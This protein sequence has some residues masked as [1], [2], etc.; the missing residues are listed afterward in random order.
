MQSSLLFSY[1]I[2]L[3]TAVSPRDIRSPC[4]CYRAQRYDFL[5]RWPNITTLDNIYHLFININQDS[6]SCRKMLSTFPKT[7]STFQKTLST[8]PKM[9]STFPKTLSTF[10]REG[11]CPRAHARA[12]AYR[13]RRNQK[14]TFTFTRIGGNAL[15]TGSPEGFRKLSERA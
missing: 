8:F 13:A 5:V 12:R 4:Y 3:S 6:P 1:H 15:Y 7:L 9:L 14:I 10:R 2:R 11:R